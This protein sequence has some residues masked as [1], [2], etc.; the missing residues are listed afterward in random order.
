MKKLLPALLYTV[1]I[2]ANNCPQWF[3]LAATEVT[4][5]MPIYD[6]S[7]TEADMDCDGIIDRL[8]NDIDGD[9]V[10]NSDE[11]A[12]GTN[13]YNPDSDGDGVNDLSDKFPLDPKEAS[14]SDDDGVGDNVDIPT[15]YP[16]TLTFTVNSE[17]N[18]IVLTGHDDTDVITYTIV[19][20][21]KYGELIG[22]PPQLKYNPNENFIGKDS[23]TFKVNDSASSSKI[24]TVDIMVTA[25]TATMYEDA[26]SGDTSKWFVSDNDP[27]GATI[28]NV[29]ENGSHVIKFQ[30]D[31]LLNAYEMVHNWHNTTQKN[32]R[33][34]MNFNENFSIFF[35]IETQK[36]YRSLYY[37][38]SDRSST[39]ASYIQIGLGSYVGWRTIHRNLEA[40]LREFEPDNAI[41]EVEGIRVRGSGYIDNIMLHNDE[42]P[43][44]Y[45]PTI[46]LNGDKKVSIALN[47]TYIDAG[48]TAYDSDDGDITDKIVV[49]NSVDT[50]EE[51]VYTVTYNVADKAGHDAKEIIR[52][53]EVIKGFIGSTLTGDPDYGTFYTALISETKKAAYLTAYYGIFIVDISNPTKPTLRKEIRNYHR[54]VLSKDEQTAY[55]FSESNFY[56]L[57]LQN[58]YEPQEIGSLKFDNTDYSMGPIALSPDGTKAYVAR[59]DKGIYVVDI[60]DP[61]SPKSLG[62]V[63]DIQ[64]VGDITFS[65]DGNILYITGNRYRDGVFYVYDVSNASSPKELKKITEITFAGS[66]QMILTK[67]NNTLYL[68]GDYIYVV[69]ISTPTNAEIITHLDDIRG[70]RI[71]LSEDETYMLRPEIYGGMVQVIDVSSQRSPKYIGECKVSGKSPYDIYVSNNTNRLYAIDYSGEFQ[72]LDLSEWCSEYL[73]E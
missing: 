68:N 24:A 19:T 1:V 30:G 13:V 8:D 37:D 9:G 35:Y 4:V 64:Y 5:V 11:I 15:A 63:F 67:D 32:A 7:I 71:F 41:V 45:K 61:R 73:G 51:G 22:N 14:D 29:Y 26:E 60:S 70:K 39:Y 55:A 27:A 31:G 46:T 20:E 69:D 3:P 16:Q 59:G 49:Q 25:P 54:I 33:W 56:V 28:T 48:A 6:K 2:N 34:D 52:T 38:G 58:P 57:D 53:V 50:T 44:N 66:G 21:P 40:D 17:N 65:K 62:K 12:N 18:I 36:G 10:L 42:A 23:F 72:I 43:D 47:A